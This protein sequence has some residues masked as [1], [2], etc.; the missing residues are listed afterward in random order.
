MLPS[1]RRIKRSL[2][3][4]SRAP[5]EE[6]GFHPGIDLNPHIGRHLVVAGFQEENPVVQCR[7][8]PDGGRG[9]GG[10]TRIPD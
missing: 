2:A 8:Q 1:I 7:H 4:S 10:R 6:P 3:A 9:F 5:N